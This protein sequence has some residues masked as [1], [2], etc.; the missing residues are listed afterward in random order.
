MVSFQSFV[1]DVRVRHL[2]YFR[3][4]ET[5]PSG[6]YEKLSDFLNLE[7][8]TE[9]CTYVKNENNFNRCIRTHCLWAKLCCGQFYFSARRDDMNNRFVNKFFVI[10]K[11][12]FAKFITPVTI[13]TLQL[14]LERYVLNEYIGVIQIKMK[15]IIIKAH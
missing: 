4:K 5:K 8:T 10:L 2:K 9:I 14:R 1:R 12:S 7:S 3:C 15:Y 6:N 13:H 11:Y